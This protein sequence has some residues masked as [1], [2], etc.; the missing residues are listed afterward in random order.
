MIEYFLFG[1]HTLLTAQNILIIFFGTFLGIIFGAIPGLTASMAVAL[2]L[3]I[4]FGMDAMAGFALLIALYIGGVSGGLISAIVLNIPGTPSSIATCF[5]GH[6]MAK[7]GEAGKALGVAVFYSFLG[8]IFGILI[9]VFIAP[10]LAKIAVQFGSYE[11]FALAVFSLTLIS[12]LAGKSLTKGIASGA[13]GMILAMVGLAPIDGVS[14]FTFGIHEFDNGFDLL[15]ALIGLYAISEIMKSSEN[16]ETLGSSNLVTTQI[17]GFGFSLAEFKSQI[18]NFFRSSLIGT[19]IGIL[20]GIGGGT[21]NLIA[22][23][24][25]RK[26]SKYPEKFG[27]GIID[28]IIA[29]EASNNACIGGAMIPLLTLGIPGD[30]VTAMLLGG[31]TIHG[32]A[33][34]PLLFSNNPQFIYTVF[35]ALILASI[36]M[37]VLEYFGMRIFI[38]LLTIPKYYILPVV[39]VLCLVG[40][41]GINNRMFDVWTLLLFGF[42]GYGFEKLNFPLPPIILGFI[43]GPMAETNLRRGLQMSKGSFLPFFTNPISGA[44]L[45]IAILFVLITAIKEIHK[46]TTRTKG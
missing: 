5:D 28:G 44:F 11:Y 39:L 4:S 36:A 14:R 1:F 8:T 15:P 21:A 2:C 31:F 46:N 12:G 33:P 18:G 6:P 16:R 40:S 20:P 37:V 23:M 25:A 43:L 41:Y 32:L 34:G 38:K 7:K 29:S 19:G 22:Y 3:P 26:R 13:S 27:T 10:P 45:S 9:L 24:A 17:K 30:G 42:L 35:S